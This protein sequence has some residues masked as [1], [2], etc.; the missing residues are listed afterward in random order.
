VIRNYGSA[1][2]KHERKDHIRRVAPFDWVSVHPKVKK[3][4]LHVKAVTP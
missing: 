2:K 1:P 3:V 4:H